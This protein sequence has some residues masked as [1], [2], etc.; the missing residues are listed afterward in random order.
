MEQAKKRALQIKK[1]E[2][3][4]KILEINKGDGNEVFNSIIQEKH[5][6]IQ[7]LKK[8]LKLPSEGPVQTMELKTVFQEKEV[9]H[10]E[11]QNTKAIVG[12]IKDQKSALV[13]QIKI[14]KEKWIKC[15]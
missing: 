3:E 13:D 10:T 11:L 12:T 14:F 1:S 6:E 15:P 2:L 4:K 5:I 8:K 9:L 7:S